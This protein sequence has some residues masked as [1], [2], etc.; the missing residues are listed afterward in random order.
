[1]KIK[2]KL[3]SDTCVSSGES[4]LGIVDTEVVFDKYGIP[5]IPA[6]RIKGLLLESSKDLL[7]LGVTNQENI[8]EI[9]GIRG[10]NK[11]Q[12]VHFYDATI[13]GYY[14]FYEN[15]KKMKN[16]EK[17]K[18][19]ANENDIKNYF[20]YVRTQTKI[21]EDGVAE[22]N[23]L[24]NIRVIKKGLEFEAY[25]YINKQVSQ[26]SKDL[27]KKAAKMIR[28]IGVSRTR[29]L[30]EVKCEITDKTSNNKKESI[31]Q[32]KKYENIITYKIK[33][34]QPC[35]IDESYI[36]GGVILGIFAGAYLRKTKN[37]NSNNA[38]KDEVFRRLFLSNNVIYECAYPSV[39]SK[40]FYPMPLSMLKEKDGFD[41]EITDLAANNLND[42]ENI[43]ILENK[44]KM[45]EEFAL[46]EDEGQMLKTLNVEKEIIYHHQRANDRTIGHVLRDDEASNTDKGQLFNY[47]SIVKGTEFIGRIKV[48]NDNTDDLDLLQNIICDESKIYIGKSKSSQYGLARIN[49]IDTKSVETEE[50]YNKVVITLQSPMI[51]VDE[52]GMDITDLKEVAR[53]VL[54][55]DIK[56][57][58]INCYGDLIC[59]SGYNAKWNMPKVQHTAIK[60]GS[61]IVVNNIDIDDK[62][63]NEL[64]NQYYGE[65][66][67]EGYGKI[68]INS[69]GIEDEEI[70]YATYE[71]IN[72]DTISI[73]DELYKDIEFEKYL[74]YEYL[75]IL[76]EVIYTNDKEDYYSNKLY[77]TLENIKKNT[78]MSNVI[79]MVKVSSSFKDIDEQL[80]KA[81]ERNNVKNNDVYKD[82]KICIGDNRNENVD[83]KDIEIGFKNFGTRKLEN[84]EFDLRGKIIGIL[85][86]NSFELFKSWFLN[87]LNRI[88]LNRRSIE[89]GECNE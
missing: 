55:E 35:V 72:I 7:D 38:H 8:D 10:S 27:L 44:Q 52:F 9:F 89:R 86:E 80:N 29:G 77:E 6:K 18:I 64:Q 79:M 51:L 73:M 25:I 56:D 76:K 58:D 3:Q 19:L 45:S 49:Y 53:A 43:E 13:K 32:I 26:E 21:G 70:E 63:A 67:N 20:T 39:D 57:K 66:I 78:I 28:H 41:D 62:K 59:T 37:T 85:E 11:F 16:S 42:I 2:I 1:M 24:R 15:I 88:K 12:N 40:A 36:P 83:Y 71:K 81:M 87:I 31:K 82:I 30:G 47:K 60:Q 5:I 61:V 4:I 22:T 46:I 74:K 65:R 50:I 23:S 14:N 68:S 48:N 69:H 17:Y 34:E 75:N 54:K 33:L 84:I